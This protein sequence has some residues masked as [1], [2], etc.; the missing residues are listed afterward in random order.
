MAWRVCLSCSSLSVL[1]WNAIRRGAL[2]RASRGCN[3]FSSAG[4][5]SAGLPAPGSCCLP[6]ELTSGLLQ[7]GQLQHRQE[8]PLGPPVD[9]YR[10]QFP[11]A[12]VH[13][14]LRDPVH[15]ELLVHLPPGIE[16]DRIAVLVLGD[17]R[18]HL[19]LVL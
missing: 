9:P 18:R 2:R 3:H 10:G 7:R 14:T 12:V 5:I 4:A 16:Q 13:K 19:G 17:E 15:P 1:C 6:R 8:L 11:I